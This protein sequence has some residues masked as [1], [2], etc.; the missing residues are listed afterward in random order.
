VAQHQADRVVTLFEEHRLGVDVAHRHQLRVLVLHKVHLRLHLAVVHVAVEGR[1]ARGDLAALRQRQLVGEHQ[2][3]QGAPAGQLVAR[4]AQRRQ[5]RVGGGA[6]RQAHGVQLGAGLDALA[7]QGRARGELGGARGAVEQQAAAQHAA[8]L[9][10]HPVEGQLHVQRGAAQA[11]PKLGD[12][13]LQGGPRRDRKRG[14]VV[15]VR[16][17]LHVGA[18]LRVRVARVRQ[19]VGGAQHEA[20]GRV[21]VGGAQPELRPGGALGDGHEP[22]GLA[23]GDKRPGA[24]AQ[25]RPAL[26]RRAAAAAGGQRQPPRLRRQDDGAHHGDGQPE[27]RAAPG[28]GGVEALHLGVVQALWQAGGVHLHLEGAAGVVQEERRGG[29]HPGRGGQQRQLQVYGQPLQP[30]VRVLAKARLHLHP[31]RRTARKR[32]HT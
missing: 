28:V 1:Q 20:L 11:G 17:Q 25:H 21:V 4:G 3:V 10:L 14:Q 18:V 5:R 27:Q 22:A 29:G 7:A 12:G 19:H 30:H 16:R 8:R 15:P 2:P 31:A 24:Q 9:E 13:Q 6:Q 32:A 26:Q 23:A